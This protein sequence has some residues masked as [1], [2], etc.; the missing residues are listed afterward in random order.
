MGERSDIIVK[1]LKDVRVLF[2]FAVLAMA[3]SGCGAGG[4]DPNTSLTGVVTDIDGKPVA[5]ARVS[6]TGG[7]ATSLSNGTFTVSGV[8]TGYR[9]VSA[10]ITIEGRRWSGQTVVDIV[11]EERNRSVN[12]VVSDDRYHARIVGTVIDPLGYVLEGAKV[13]VNGPWGSTM[14]VTD[15]T[16]AYEV[17]K[18]TPGVT[19]TVS[20]SLA[21]YVNDERTVSLTA[22]ETRSVSF[23]VG[24]GTFQGTIPAPQNVAAQAWTIS[25]SVTRAAGRDP[26]HLAWLKRAYRQKRGLPAA[27][28]TTPTTRV[29]PAGSVI[30][31]DLFWDYRSWDDLFGYAVKRG[32]SANPSIVN[33]VLRDPLASS[34]FDVDPALTP[35]TTYHY[36]IHCLDTIGFP[37]DGRVGPA[38]DNVTARPLQG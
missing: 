10:S 19:Y 28:R 17:P 18:L 5:G 23:A 15:A 4:S 7:A 27:P 6:V 33:A 21:G 38:S 14:D 35:N 20:C 24:D 3:L 26:G 32:T 22:S 31:V 37:S 29:T 1:R 36:T 25:A 34:Y 16:G 11:K 13:F 8:G 2:G 12:I 9:T 30:E